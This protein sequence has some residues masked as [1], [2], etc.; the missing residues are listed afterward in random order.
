MI[1]VGLWLG[2][3]GYGV[4]YAGVV[5]LG[6]GTCSLGQAFRGGCSG[7]ASGQAA[8]TSSSGTTVLGAVQQLQ[9]QQASSVPTTPIATG[10]A[11]LVRP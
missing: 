8:S 6:G 7:G 1:L 5:K 11:T 9:A 3:V 2:I 10:S 4:L